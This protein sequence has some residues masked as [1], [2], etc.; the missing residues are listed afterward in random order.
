MT[1]VTPKAYIIDAS[2][3]EEL[4]SN[5]RFQLENVEGWIAQATRGRAGA[6]EV[7]AIKAECLLTAVQLLV[8]S[9]KNAEKSAKA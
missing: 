8:D 9:F 3:P 5:C 1:S 7:A 4:A 6:M 2:T